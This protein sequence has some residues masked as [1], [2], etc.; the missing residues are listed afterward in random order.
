VEALVHQFRTVGVLAAS[1]IEDRQREPGRPCEERRTLLGRLVERHRV[2][3]LA[4]HAVRVAALELGRTHRERVHLA[5]AG[6]LDAAGDEARLSDAG[7][8]LDRHEA[9]APLDGA[10]KRLV[11][12]EQLWLP[13]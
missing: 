10:G 12:R 1:G 7:R 3:R 8:A 11:E 9:A 5:L 2:G 4:H 6:A 13:L